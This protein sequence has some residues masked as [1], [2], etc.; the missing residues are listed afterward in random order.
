[1]IVAMVV[2]NAALGAVQEGRAELGGP[3][4]AKTA[5]A[6]VRWWFEVARPQPRWMLRNLVPGDVVLLSTPATAR[7][8]TAGFWRR[9]APGARRVLDDRRVEGACGQ[10]SRTLI[11]RRQCR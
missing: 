4:C 1:M 3:L 7:P 9:P 2:L 11:Y 10:A 5:F 6:D 8:P